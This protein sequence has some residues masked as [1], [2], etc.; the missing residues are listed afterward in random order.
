MSLDPVPLALAA[1]AGAAIGAVHFALLWRSVG[2]LMR[3]DT[4]PAQFAV[5]SLLRLLAL[6]GIVGGLA[7]LGADAAELLAGTLGFLAVRLAATR[8]AR[9]G[10]R[11]RREARG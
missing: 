7:A 4:H 6:A 5:L 10:D 11:T 9:P 3:A 2:R 8:L 1:L